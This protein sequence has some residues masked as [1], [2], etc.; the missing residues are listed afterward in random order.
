MDDPAGG[1]YQPGQ[2]R[3]AV[4][5]RRS[6][7][8][9]IGQA[10]PEWMDD[11]DAM[12]DSVVGSFD[13]TGQFQAASVSTCG[14]MVD[15]KS[16]LNRFFQGDVTTT[17]KDS[18]QETT[19]KPSADAKQSDSASAPTTPASADVSAKTASQAA[20]NSGQKAALESQPSADKGSK[21]V[22]KSIPVESLFSSQPA[23][24]PD[25]PSQPFRDNTAA[26][27]G[28]AN[29]QKEGRR[30]PKAFAGLGQQEQPKETTSGVTAD[31]SGASMDIGKLLGQQKPVPAYSVQQ[32]QQQQN[33]QGQPKFVVPKTI[34]SSS[35]E[36]FTQLHE[37]VESLVNSFS[38][39]SLG[40]GGVGGLV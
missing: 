14:C 39:V 7:T 20:S 35:D 24:K 10:V 8:A 5:Q 2:L 29:Q 1:G 37:D 28:L 21:I 36:V 30:L 31:S 27:A 22:G 34:S 40:S 4:S 13:A 15:S 11:D 12:D 19:K 38:A 23:T 32:Q 17:A 6:Y 16:K 18:S 3:N 25:Q 9:P 33:V 26:N